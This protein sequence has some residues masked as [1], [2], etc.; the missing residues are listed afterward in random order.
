MLKLLKL[1]FGLFMYLRTELK[2]KRTPVAL[3]KFFRDL[4]KRYYTVML[5]EYK[6]VFIQL[7]PIYQKQKADFD[8]QQKLRKDL[9]HAY[10]IAQ[11]LLFVLPKKMGKNHYEQKRIR[12]DFIK[13]GELPKDLVAQLEK[14]IG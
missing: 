13:H 11:Y 5:Q 1:H 3:V 8:K 9:H 2:K 7:D 12:A 14:E 10:K 4:A 6:N